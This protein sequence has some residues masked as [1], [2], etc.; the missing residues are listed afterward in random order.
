M[1]SLGRKAQAFDRMG[2]G[3]HLPDRLRAALRNRAIVLAQRTVRDFLADDCPHLAAAIAYYSFFSLFP[4]L[5]GLVSILGYVFGLTEVRGE[6]VAWMTGYLPGSSEL[7]EGNVLRVVKAREE[8]GTVAVLGFLWSATSVFGAVRKALNTAWDLDRSRPL[9]KQK[10]I[11]L[12]MVGGVGVLFVLSTTITATYRLLI[13]WRFLLLDIQPLRYELL[14]SLIAVALPALVTFVTF[15]F[16]YRTVPYCE[17]KL[18]SAAL[19]AG[20]ATT[21]FELAK[22]LFVWYAQTFGRYELV[23]GS[24]GG[25]IS[26]LTWIYFSS[27]VLLLGAEL[28]AEHGKMN[29]QKDLTAR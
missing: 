7:V 16:I 8:I 19:G 29:R 12:A 6:L 25:V 13:E 1:P 27:L 23:Y 28:A 17:V 14:G 15:L 2:A 4:L 18:S 9:L 22:N 20:L 5:L 24:L 11:D 3:R 26:L 21:L 10:L